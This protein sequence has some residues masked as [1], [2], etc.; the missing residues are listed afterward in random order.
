MLSSKKEVLSIN[1]L[2]VVV[3]I[4]EQVNRYTGD[5]DAKVSCQFNNRSCQ[6]IGEYAVVVRGQHIKPICRNT[7]GNGAELWKKNGNEILKQFQLL[8]A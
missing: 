4:D 8:E 2:F 7:S 1:N 6:N 5:I 3:E